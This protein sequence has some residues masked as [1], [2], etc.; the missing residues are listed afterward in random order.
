MRLLVVNA[1]RLEDDGNAAGGP[2]RHLSI[3]LA[4]PMRLFHN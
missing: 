1:A 3:S 4:T 2:L